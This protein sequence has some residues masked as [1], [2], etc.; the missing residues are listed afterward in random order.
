MS[1]LVI[2]C[3][4]CKLEVGHQCGADL[5]TSFVKLMTWRP[6]ENNP[7]E[8]IKKQPY[9]EKGPEGEN[10]GDEKAP[11]MTEAYLYN[12]LGK[13]DARTLLALVRR[14]A[15]A[16]GIDDM[17]LH[18]AVG[19]AELEYDAKQKEKRRALNI[20]RVGSAIRKAGAKGF[21]VYEEDWEFIA[22]LEKLTD[23]YSFG[24]IGTSSKDNGR[25][26]RRVIYTERS[27]KT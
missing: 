1:D 6:E 21:V 10:D 3:N 13:E 24:T 9:Y 20:H 17:G 12:L 16:A 4:R 15:I 23:R 19:L 26:Y 7:A 22:H 2:T 11:L 27:D 8:F 25:K 5:L 14:C 18:K